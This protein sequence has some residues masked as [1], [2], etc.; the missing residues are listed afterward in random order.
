MWKP[1][2]FPHA[3]ARHISAKIRWTFADVRPWAK[4]FDLLVCGRRAHRR[5]ARKAKNHVSQ[6]SP[7]T[8]R[9]SHKY[10][11]NITSLVIYLADL[12]SAH[13]QKVLES[14]HPHQS[15]S[16]CRSERVELG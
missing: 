5:D 3:E 9:H 4:P 8:Y 11:S 7:Y 2:I 12:K 6:H 16:C 14:R 13:R 10:N 15:P 1:A